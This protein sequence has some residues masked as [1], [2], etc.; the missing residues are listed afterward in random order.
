MRYD[1][2]IAG[3]LVSMREGAADLVNGLLHYTPSLTEV[4][5][6]VGAISLC[7]LLYT[8]AERLLPLSPDEH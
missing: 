1:L 5:I 8:L 3:Q 6:V 4:A 2:V 7:L